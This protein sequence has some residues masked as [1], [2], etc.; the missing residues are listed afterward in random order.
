ME[1]GLANQVIGYTNGMIIIALLLFIYL[2]MGRQLPGFCQTCEC[3]EKEP[4]FAGDKM[5]CGKE[6]IYNPPQ[7]H[8]A[9]LSHYQKVQEAA[10]PEVAQ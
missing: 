3:V 2:G 5:V 4:G 10:P 7:R 1:Y 8:A 9:H 6:C